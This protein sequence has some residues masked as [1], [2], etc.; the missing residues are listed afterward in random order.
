MAVAATASRVD[1]Q[2]VLHEPD[3]HRKAARLQYLAHR[4]R[5]RVL[6]ILRAWRLVRGVE[7]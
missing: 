2:E 4:F 6:D 5:I 7:T 1:L 3:R